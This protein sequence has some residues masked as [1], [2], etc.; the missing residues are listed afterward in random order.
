MPHQKEVTRV[1]GFF[2]R[3]Q[4]LFYTLQWYR[5]ENFMGRE[6]RY[7]VVPFRRQQG[8]GTIAKNA[9]CVVHGSLRA[10]NVP[11]YAGASPVIV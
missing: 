10:V 1:F 9:L 3:R 8:G 11:E 7:P 4:E 6:A 2:Y 5:S